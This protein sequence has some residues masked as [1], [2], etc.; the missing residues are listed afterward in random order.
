VRGGVHSKL[1]CYGGY[2]LKGGLISGIAMPGDSDTTHVAITGG[3]GAYEG[4][5]G[6]A[7]EVSRGDNSPLTDVTIHLIYP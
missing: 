2:S 6:S 7:V 4:V 1:A 5:T 3:T